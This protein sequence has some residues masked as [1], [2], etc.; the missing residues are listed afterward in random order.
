MT[1]PEPSDCTRRGVVVSAALLVEELVEEVLEGRAFRKLWRD[2]AAPLPPFEPVMVCAVE[3]LT[4]ASSKAERRDRQP[5]PGRAP[6]PGRRWPPSRE[7]RRV[8][9]QSLRR[10][11]ASRLQMIAA[12]VYP[13]DWAGARRDRAARAPCT[14]GARQI[15]LQ[16]CSKYGRNS[17]IHARTRRRAKA[18]S[19]PAAPHHWAWQ[20]ARAR[21]PRAPPEQAGGTGGAA[22]T[23]AVPGRGAAGGGR[24][25]R[26][27]RRA[28]DADSARQRIDLSGRDR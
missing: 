27:S 18:R 3:M 4:T 14:P 12:I 16:S 20:P 22:A 11:I 23:A 21:A 19:M 8:R 13:P 17:D 24:M 26:R 28:S 2:A 5:T 25:H 10:R 1:K 6:A 7:P 15:G 9:A